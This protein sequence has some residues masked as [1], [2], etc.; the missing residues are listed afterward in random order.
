MDGVWNDSREWKIHSSPNLGRVWTGESAVTVPTLM[1][2]SKASRTHRELGRH[3]GGESATERARKV[4]DLGALTVPNTSFP[5]VRLRVRQEV[6]KVPRGNVPACPFGG[7][8]R[9]EDDTAERAAAAGVAAGVP[10]GAQLPGRT[11]GHGSARIAPAPTEHAAEGIRWGVGPGSSLRP[12]HR[13]VV[14]GSESSRAAAFLGIVSTSGELRHAR[15]GAQGRSRAGLL[16]PGGVSSRRLLAV[17]L[18]FY[19]AIGSQRRAVRGI[20][21]PAIG[22]QFVSRWLVTSG[23]AAGGTRSVVFP[24]H[25]KKSIFYMGVLALPRGLE[26]LSP[27]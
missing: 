6:A 10:G 19:A 18:R 11:G 5:H 12:E 17:N 24:K 25:Q 1:E 3:A 21:S 4:A 27:P 26:P 15:G 2:S 16:R 22:A 8:P 13:C 7:T 9:E 14:L 23:G 20:R